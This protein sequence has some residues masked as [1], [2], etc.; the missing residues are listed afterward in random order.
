VEIARGIKEKLNQK[1]QKKEKKKKK[2]KRKRIIE[3][4]S[5]IVGGM[6]MATKIKTQKDQ[7]GNLRKTIQQDERQK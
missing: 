5:G 3:A 2:K 6:T 7:C 1:T 4:E